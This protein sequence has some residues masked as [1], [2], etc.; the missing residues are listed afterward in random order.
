MKKKEIKNI[1][2]KIVKYES[3][4]QNST[5]QKEIEQAKTAI[6]NLSHSIHSL[7]DMVAIDEE[8]QT[9]LEQQNI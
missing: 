9:I 4:I 3:I 2:K 5:D 1:A 7:E 6:F 8:V